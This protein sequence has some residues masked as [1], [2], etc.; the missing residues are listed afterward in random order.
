MGDPIHRI[1][2]FQVPWDI[3]HP[4]GEIGKKV[5]ILS[6]QNSAE[7]LSKIFNDLVTIDNLDLFHQGT[8]I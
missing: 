7:L 8:S 5:C 6:R 3:H 4:M 1:V 2:L